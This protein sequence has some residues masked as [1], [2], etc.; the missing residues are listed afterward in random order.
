MIRTS[1]YSKL[2]LSYLDKIAY[3]VKILPLPLKECTNEVVRMF[4]HVIITLVRWDVSLDECHLSSLLH[5]LA[6]FHKCWFWVPLNKSLDNRGD[7]YA[8]NN[9]DVQDMPRH[10][11]RKT[12][13]RRPGE[14]PVEIIIGHN[15]I[16]WLWQ[17]HV[18]GKAGLVSIV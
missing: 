9:W 18:F 14:W 4:L 8:Y 13:C 3:N 15:N 17:L 5:S 16:S 11:G 6:C 10:K 7:C 12:A 1:V 2:C